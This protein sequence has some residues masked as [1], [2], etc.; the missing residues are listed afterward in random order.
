MNIAI[1]ARVN[2]LRQAEQ[3][4]ELANQIQSVEAWA[5]ANNHSIVKT[6]VD[7]GASA[8]DN[9]RPE[10]QRMIVEAI[11]PDH[12][13]GAIVVHSLSRL[14]RDATELKLLRQ[15]LSD[16]NVQIIS[17][18]QLDY[19]KEEQTFGRIL[20]LFTE[21]DLFKSAAQARCKHT[22]EWD[23]QTMMAVRWFCPR[24]GK[25]ELR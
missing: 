15:K 9:K 14:T 4:V 18:T 25:S 3:D 20:D 21:K 23:G 13:Y 22:W 5:V 19:T 24:C 8:L 6:F 1:Y 11:S 12:P 7:R 10:F 16:W 2:V 17:I